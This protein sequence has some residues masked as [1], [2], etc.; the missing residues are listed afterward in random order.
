MADR[1]VRAPARALTAVRAMAPV[2]GMPPTDGRGDR[3]RGPGRPAPGPGR[4]GSCRRGRQPPW[5]TADSPWRRG[6]PPPRPPR[7]AGTRAR[8]GG[9]AGTPIDE[10]RAPIRVTSQPGDPG[11]GGGG[12]HGERG[13]TGSARWNRGSPTIRTATTATRARD[14][15]PGR[16]THASTEWKATTAVPEPVGLVMP[17]RGGHLF[18]E[19]DHGDADG[20]SLDDRPRH[21]GHHP[22]EAG[23]PGHQHQDP[24]DETDRRDRPGPEPGD[25]GQED[26]GHRPGRSGHLEVRA[27]EHS[28][29][30]SGDDRG[31][32]T[33]RRGSG[34]RRWR[35]A[36]ASGRATT[37]TVTPATT[38]CFQECA[39]SPVV[40]GSG[41]EAAHP[42]APTAPPPVR[43]RRS[44]PDRRILEAGD[45]VAG[46]VEGAEE[47][48]P[49]RRH[50]LD[51]ARDP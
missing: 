20:E 37:P 49:G 22:A 45:Q 27:P 38:S 10:G 43:V 17:E 39:R 13:T 4:T 36:R 16:S 24:G 41:K 50:Q 2:D 33:D 29:D 7:R 42:G 15:T 6:R 30:Q 26:H 48:P 40:G 12:H 1:R 11:D 25:D 35:S 21:V 3:G 31:G 32:E 47:E 9:S 18:E 51:R 46:L 34:R 28:G 5:P 19:D 44:R 8:A 14:S 23:H